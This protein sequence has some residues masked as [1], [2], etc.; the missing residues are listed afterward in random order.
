MTEH[1]PAGALSAGRVLSGRGTAWKEGAIAALLAVCAGVSALVTV[2][3]VL[4][5]LRE[6]VTFFS[7]VSPW[8]FLTGTRWTPLFQEKHFGVL[9]LLAGSVLVMVGA[10]LVAL[11]AGLL[12]GIYLSEYAGP[13][14]R[15]ALKPALQVL[16]G[17]PTVVYGYFALTFVTPLLRLLF[18]GVGLFNA[19]SAALVVGIMILPTVATLSEDALRGV[20]GGLREAAYALGANRTE[21]VTR[22]VLPAGLSGVLA[23]FV[24]ALSRA[25]GETM[26][27]SMAAGAS[28]RLT[29]NPLDSIQTLTAYIVQVGQGGVASGS[30]A[31]HTLFAVG[32]T[33][34][35][36]TLAMN[37]LGRWVG[38]RFREERA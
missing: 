27:V 12:T 35:V 17:I 2:G 18:P 9:P 32:T 20:P 28:P 38:G 4:V 24:V 10:G 37:V 13:R 22:V 11:P 26:V 16:A 33:L 7:Q 23:S 36:L 25:F 6:T 14:L 3:I 1:E 8:E 19:A 5:L 34:F 31:Y 29:L 21:V 15:S 30:L